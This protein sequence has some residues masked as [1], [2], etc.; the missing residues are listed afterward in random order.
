VFNTFGAVIICGELLPKIPRQAEL[1][2]FEGDQQCA[3]DFGARSK[4]M[5]IL[6]A[7]FGK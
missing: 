2:L 7:V 3:A 1:L 4:S 6:M 5:G